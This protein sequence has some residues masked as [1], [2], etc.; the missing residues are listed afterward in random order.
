MVLLLV[1]ALACEDTE[2]QPTAEPTLPVPLVEATDV[3]VVYASPVC[4]LPWDQ[5]EYDPLWGDLVVGQ[6]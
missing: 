5:G 3:E 6:T 4:P 2:P 1:A